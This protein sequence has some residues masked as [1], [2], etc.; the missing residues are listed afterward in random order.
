MPP[1]GKKTILPL[2]TISRVV[3]TSETRQQK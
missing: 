1:K 3:A 2:L